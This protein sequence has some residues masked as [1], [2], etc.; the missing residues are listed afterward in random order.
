[1]ENFNFYVPTDI[2]F[3]KDRL[4]ELPAVLDQFGM[5]YLFMVAVVSNVMACTNKLLIW[6]KKTGIH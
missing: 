2:R 3:G 5:S 1:M 4:D 6:P